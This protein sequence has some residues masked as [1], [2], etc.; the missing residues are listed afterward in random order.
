MCSE[1]GAGCYS[2]GIISAPFRKTSRRRE[3]RNRTFLRLLWL[4]AVFFAG[5]I[6]RKHIFGSAFAAACVQ[7]F[8]EKVAILSMEVNKRTEKT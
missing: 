7:N 3:L 5:M 4:A 8:G 2:R 1:V 6:A